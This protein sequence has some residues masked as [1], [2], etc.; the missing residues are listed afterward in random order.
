MVEE[1]SSIMKNDVW[2][3]VPRPEGKSMVTSRWIYK[4][5]HATDGSIEKYKARFVARGFSQK[6]GVLRGDVCSYR[7]IC[8]YQGSYFY[9][10]RDGVE[11]TSNGCEESFP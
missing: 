6:E 5:K 2:D 3:I 4:I 8:I 11:D 9:C 10:F 7:Q 1:Y